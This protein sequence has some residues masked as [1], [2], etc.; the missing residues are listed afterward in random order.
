METVGENAYSP[1]FGASTFAECRLM[2]ASRFWW[3]WPRRDWPAARLRV[4]PLAVDFPGLPAG[5]LR[6]A[7]GWMPAELESLWMWS[8]AC[9]LVERFSGGA[10][11]GRR[12]CCWR[13]WGGAGCVS[14]EDE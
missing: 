4:W 1:A 8:P 10:P 3:I 5:G 13:G 2:L 14:P 11:C 9:G 12:R 6:S 7:L